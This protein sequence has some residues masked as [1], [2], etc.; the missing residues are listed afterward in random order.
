MQD[1]DKR[2]AAEAAVEMVRDG[3]TIGLGTGSTANFAIRKL[4]ERVAG[5]LSIRGLPTSRASELLAHEVGIPL[6]NFTQATRL[7][8][9]LDGAD[10]MDPALNLIKGGGGALFREKIVAA[11]SDMLIIFADGTKRVSCLGAFPLPVEVNPFGWQV[12]AEK[13]KALGG[14]PVLRG[15]ESTP[16]VTDNQAHILDCAFGKIPDP[17]AL[18]SQIAAITGVMENGLF[19]GLAK[20][21]FVANNGKVEQVTPQ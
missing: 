14:N 9:T 21:A 8:L 7:D 16:F 18:E 2:L 19:C 6:V 11:A 3:M 5:G 17:P 15:G 1:D 13:L 20:I 12:V 10:E 4:G